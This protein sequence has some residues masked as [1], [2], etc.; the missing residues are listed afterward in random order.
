MEKAITFKF[1]EKNFDNPKQMQAL[2]LAY[3][4]DSIY[5][6]ISR[7]YIRCQLSFQLG[8]KPDL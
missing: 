5:D 2:T 4:G 1:T 6:I 3:I 7:E 8:R